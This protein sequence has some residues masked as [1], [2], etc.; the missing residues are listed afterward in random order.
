MHAF[1]FTYQKKKPH[2]PRPSPQINRTPNNFGEVFFSSTKNIFLPLSA[3][4][5]KRGGG[6][7]QENKSINSM[8]LHAPISL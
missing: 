2:S 7:N 1:K 4:K 8:G 5:K 3:Q 6:M